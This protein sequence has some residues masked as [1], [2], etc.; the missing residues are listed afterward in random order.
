MRPFDFRPQNLPRHLVR[1][2]VM[3]A[4]TVQ[5][6]REGFGGPAYWLFMQKTGTILVA[7]VPSDLIPIMNRAELLLE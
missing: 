1:S 2:L 3:Q 6:A 7:E 4:E 5:T